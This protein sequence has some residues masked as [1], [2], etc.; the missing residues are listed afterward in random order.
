MTEGSLSRRYAK[1]LFE[2]AR[3]EKREEA[4]G[5]EIEEFLNAY[6]GSAL[7]TVLNNP[8]IELERRKNI[9][10]Q[11]AKSI[12]LSPPSLHFLALLFDRDRLPYVQGISSFYRRL[13]NESRGRVEA[14]L[15][16]ATPLESGAMEQLRGALKKLSGKDVLLQQET[17]PELI[18][19]LSVELEGTIYDGSVETQLEKMQQQIARGR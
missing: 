15:V 17:N 2:L 7:Q 19:G 8:A 9:L 13:L 14:K 10:E 6:Q 1:A 12:Q 4:I 18:G 5:Q 16:S 11:V 3:E